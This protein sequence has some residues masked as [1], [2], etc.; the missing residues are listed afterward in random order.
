MKMEITAQ[1]PLLDRF[2]VPPV[3]TQSGV[4][5]I[6]EEVTLRPEM[7]ARSGELLISTLECR[8]KKLTLPSFIHS[9][10]ER[11]GWQAAATGHCPSWL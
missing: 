3:F 5:K 6:G 9:L 10:K 11:H 4:E 7:E 2:N 1:T 8:G